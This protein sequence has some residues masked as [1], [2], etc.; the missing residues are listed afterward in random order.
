MWRALVL[1]LLLAAPTPAPSPAPSTPVPTPTPD[2]ARIANQ[3]WEGLLRRTPGLVLLKSRWDR[4]VLEFREERLRWVDDRD[5]GKNL[6]IPGN[7]ITGQFLECARE[8]ED[9]DCF[10]W[11]FRTKAEEY[12][13]RDASPPGGRMREIYE[14]FRAI[15]PDLPSKKEKAAGR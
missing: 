5:P 1:G 9:G 4:G 7:L 15:Y 13:F 12:H 3:R 11:G 6:L 14:F 2:L 8:G 10:E